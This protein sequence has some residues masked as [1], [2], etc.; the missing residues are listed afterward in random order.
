M[1]DL[2][3]HDTGA[4]APVPAEA[5]RKPAPLRQLPAEWR[6]PVAFFYAVYSDVL[7]GTV[8]LT[9]RFRLWMKHDGLTLDEA[10]AV[11]ERL[12]RPEHAAAIQYPGQL[13]AALA[14]GVAEVVRGRRAAAEE[15]DRRR[16]W[17]AECRRFAGEGEPVGRKHEPTL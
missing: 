1:G 16:R 13:V 6:R 14:A 12:M 3:R 5:D 15:D 11:M 9:A 8:G 17:D 10:R 4:P 7:K 2:A